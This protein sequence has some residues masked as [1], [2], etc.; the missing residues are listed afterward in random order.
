MERLAQ[1]WQLLATK[2]E[3]DQT[4]T[5]SPNGDGDYQ[6]RRCLHNDLLG[7]VVEDLDEFTAIGIRLGENGEVPQSHYGR[8]GAACDI[9]IQTWE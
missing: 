9:A 3:L 5:M 6:S 2:G 8:S 7:L 4:T 1:R